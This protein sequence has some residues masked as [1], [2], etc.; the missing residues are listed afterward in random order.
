ME[1][2]TSNTSL[3]LYRRIAD[4]LAEI[5]KG[6]EFPP[7][8]RLPT[9]RELAERFSVSRPTVRE[10]L[11]ALE[12]LN[13]VE[14]RHGSGI[15]VPEASTLPVPANDSRE[16]LDV[17]AFELLEARIVIE[18]GAV[19]IAATLATDQDIADL[20]DILDRQRQAANYTEFEAVDREFHLRLA[21]ITN[22]DPLIYVIEDLWEMRSRSKLASTVDTRVRGG[23]KVDRVEEH[24]KIVD[25]LRDKDPKAAR[26]MMHQHLERVRD[27]M[28]RAT[29]MEEMQKL[30]RQQQSLRKALSERIIY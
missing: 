30:R 4:E 15:Y 28:L 9:E 10:A 14:I 29:E 24:K 13:I 25:A 3:R 1:H 27:Y 26:K 18:S 20:D 8:S 11:I 22:N 7:G 19:A 6:G 16:D 2:N 12:I 17:G 23:G 21:R 5:I